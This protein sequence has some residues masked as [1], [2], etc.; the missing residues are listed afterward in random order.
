MVSVFAYF[1]PLA[2]LFA[3][4]LLAHALPSTPSNDAPV[5][6]QFMEA[7]NSARAQHGAQPLAWDDGLVAAAQKWAEQCAFK[8]SRGR[9]GGA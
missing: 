7:H 9:Y 3:M 6:Q 4:S 1:A 5:A 2:V 8:H